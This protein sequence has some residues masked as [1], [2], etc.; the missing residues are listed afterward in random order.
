MFLCRDHLDLKDH[1]VYKE[2][3]DQWYVSDTSILKV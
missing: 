1:K 3:W 2:V